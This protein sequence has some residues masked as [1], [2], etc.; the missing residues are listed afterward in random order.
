MAE[1]AVGRRIGLEPAQRLDALAL[2][3]DFAPAAGLVR[4]DHGMN[5]PLEEIALVAAR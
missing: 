4:E 5:E 2:G 1:A 3:A